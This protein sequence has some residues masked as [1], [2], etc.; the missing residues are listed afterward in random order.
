MHA[1]VEQPKRA[2][3]AVFDAAAEIVMFRE[4]PVRAVAEHASAAFDT[5]N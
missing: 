2:Y 5:Y 1:R 4:V 3:L